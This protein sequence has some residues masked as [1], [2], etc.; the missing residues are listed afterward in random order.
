MI[1][2]KCNIWDKYRQGEI[3]C[4]TTNGFVKNDGRCVM[5]RGVAAQAKEYIPDIDLSLGSLVKEIGNVVQFCS[6]DPS[7]DAIRVISFPVKP[8]WGV[9]N[10]GKSNIVPHMRRQVEIGL[11]YPGWMMLADLEI[12]QRSLYELYI[13][14]SDL[15]WHDPDLQ[16]YL[17]RPGCGAG[18][19]D[20]EK[21]VE[22]LCAKYG[23]WL[24]V[25]HL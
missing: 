9:C 1:E 25:C 19:L 11:S 5:G 10:I 20:W 2:K 6:E 15:S 3:V 22:P 8:K 17:P 16:I 21:Q 24:V 13:L 7:T 23:D 12:I 14:W 4:I 18:C